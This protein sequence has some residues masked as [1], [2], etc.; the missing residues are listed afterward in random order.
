MGYGDQIMATGFAKG[1]AAR[2][3][4]MAFGDGRKIMWDQHS[5]EIFRNNPNIAAPG[6]EGRR[7]LIWH[8]YRKGN[9]IY[10]QHD[11]ERNRWVWNYD[12][13]PIPGEIYFDPDER[14]WAAGFVGGVGAAGFV[15]IE[16]DVPHWKSVAPNKQW[17]TPRYDEIVRRLWKAGIQVLQFRT[18]KTRHQ[19]PHAQVISTPTFRHACALM[20][21]SR[22]YIGAEGG[23]HHA[24]AALGKPGVV[25]FGGFVPP[26]V[27]GYE[28]HT[29]LTGGA[30]ACGSLSP[31]RHCREALE[32]ISV[33]EVWD[34]TTKLLGID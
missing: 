32:R 27:T 19:A 23:L 8:E 34:A 12:F 7:D 21:R 16:P 13:R 31:C 5:A 18:G 9:R 25:L 20:E 11:P 17:P 28:T 3:Q 10:N 24:A 2:G 26:E 6:Q 15:V 30:E 22:A 14:R 29:N 1:T 4:R 33:D